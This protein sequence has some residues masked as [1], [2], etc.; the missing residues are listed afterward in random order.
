M[1]HNGYRED[2]VFFCTQNGVALLRISGQVI[3]NEYLVWGKS[4]R[5]K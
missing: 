3:K 2:E 1:S 5:G 4:R